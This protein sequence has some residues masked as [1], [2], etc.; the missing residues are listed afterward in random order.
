MIKVTTNKSVFQLFTLL[1]FLSCKPLIDNNKRRYKDE[2]LFIENGKMKYAFVWRTCD[3]CAPIKNLGIRVDVKLND[4][5]LLEVK[6]IKPKKW[7]QLL[8]E[9]KSDYVANLILYEI[10]NRSATQLFIFE[11][12]R[13][14]R[15][16]LKSEDLKYWDSV[17]VISPQ[18]E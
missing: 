17:F 1:L 10:Y 8:R 7:K 9:N 3:S 5:E 2:L 15:K 14:W 12:V 4:N 13:E 11:G 6:R 16:Y 18:Q